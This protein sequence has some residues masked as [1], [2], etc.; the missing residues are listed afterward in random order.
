[1]GKKAAYFFA[2]VCIILVAAGVY[3]INPF[4]RKVKAGLQVI[5]HN[6]TASLFLNDQYLDKAPYINKKIQPGTY[7]LRIIPDN[8]DFAAYETSITL[9]RGTLAVVIWYPGE[10][11]EQSGGVIYELEP[12]TN[13]KQTEV[14]FISEPDNAIIQFDDKEQIFAPTVLKDVKQGRHEFEVSLPSFGKQQHTV[15]ILP[16]YRTK[17]KIKLSKEKINNGADQPAQIKNETATDSAQT[18][19]AT[20]SDSARDIALQNQSTDGAEVTPLIMIKSTKYFQQGVEVLRVR[21]KPSTGG[22][23]VGF[24]ESGK[25]YPYLGE[26]EN[27]WHHIQ[28]KDALDKSNKEGWVSG[29]FAQLVEE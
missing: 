5:T 25:T 2:I 16:G 9:N 8:S 28:F 22:Q 18:P 17:I 12:L 10:T 14:S 19:P 26:T 24:V 15:Q 4:A 29:Q 11:L 23:S 20:Q 27:G 6:S 7:D 13:K 21:D 1:M 3:I